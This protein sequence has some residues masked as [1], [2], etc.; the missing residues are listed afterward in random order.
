MKTLLEY[1]YQKCKD[2]NYHNI[3]GKEYKLK[4]EILGVHQDIYDK[5]VYLARDRI[6]LALRKNMG[7]L[8]CKTIYLLKTTNVSETVSQIV[9]SFSGYTGSLWRLAMLHAVASYVISKTHNS[10]ITDI[11][12]TCDCYLPYSNNTKREEIMS[13]VSLLSEESDI[14]SYIEIYYTFDHFLLP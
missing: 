3:I 11:M 1:S 2:L 8:V 6:R 12:D 9:G 7:Q 13:K 14:F 4:R 5:I 10:R